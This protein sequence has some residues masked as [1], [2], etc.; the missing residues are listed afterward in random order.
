MSR[1]TT[2][3]LVILLLLTCALS[4]HAAPAQPAATTATP[5]HPLLSDLRVRRAIAYCSDRAALAASVY[6]YLDAN[7]RNALLMDTFLPK[8]HWAY[9]APD[10][11]YR[12]PYDPAVGKALLEQAGW[13]HSQGQPYRRNTEGYELAVSFR[14]TTAQFRQTWAAVLEAQLRECGIH[15]VREHLPASWLFGDTTGFQRRDF[16]L[17]AYA[18][19]G[20]SDPKGRTLYACDQIPTEENGWS[21]QNYMGWCNLAASAAIIAANSTMNRAERIAQY[22]IVQREFAKD[23]VSLP[24]FQRVEPVAWSNHLQGARVSPTEYVTKSAKDWTR[25]DG[26]DT[27][28]LAW[29]Q[30]P[31]SLFARV[32][33]AAVAHQ[34]YDLGVGVRHSQYDYDYQP[35]LQNPLSTVDSGLAKVA[36]VDVKSGDEVYTADSRPATRAQ[37][38]RVVD[39][40]GNVIEYDGSSVIQ[41]KQLTVTYKF[42]PFTWSDGAPGSAADLALGYRTD[43]DYES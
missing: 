39:A 17:T 11:Q 8:N 32:E 28:T 18:W 4:A 3:I 21:G 42:K 26:G 34:A 43:C 6:P 25:N 14:T 10:P 33:N 20:E 23:M 40:N 13:T 37:G 9:A 22:G 30:E 19:V 15:L 2:L 27:A 7:Q 1:P 5:P 38:V 16:E 35:G 12:Y 36:V 29:S 41:M 24:L 31:P